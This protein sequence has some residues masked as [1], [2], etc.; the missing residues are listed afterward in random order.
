MKIHIG[1]DHAGHRLKA[2]LVDRLTALGYDLIDCGPNTYRED[3]NHPS[4]VIE[5]AHRTVADPRN[6]G[7]VI[8]GSGNGEVIA[9]NKVVDVYAALAWSEGTARP[10]REH[11]DADV[12]APG[13]CTHCAETIE[14][15][16]RTFL[17]AQSSHDLRH[18]RRID[19]LHAYERTGEIPTAV[20]GAAPQG[21]GSRG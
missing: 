16:V 10:A 15:P 21:A 7:I 17:T 1:S 3:G 20:D 14:K 18:T 11:N 5:A 19:M 4:Y 9:A 8:G 13:A 6:R 2:R 12:I